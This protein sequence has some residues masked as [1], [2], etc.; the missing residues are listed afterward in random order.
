MEYLI[1]AA[2]LLHAVWVFFD[3]HKRRRHTLGEAAGWGLGTLVLWLFV[4]PLY[5]AQRH[6]RAGET[7]EGGD[8]WNYL[9]TFAVLWTIVML[10]VGAHYILAASEVA[11]TAHTSAG[12]VGAAIGATLGLGVVAAAWFFPVLGALLLGLVLK[13]A[14]IVEKGPTGP[15]ALQAPG[16]VTRGLTA[17]PT[18]GNTPLKGMPCPTCGR[19]VPPERKRHG[20]LV[21]LVVMVTGLVIGLAIVGLLRGREVPKAIPATAP[22]E[23]A[24][25]GPRA[26]AVHIAAAADQPEVNHLSFAAFKGEL[27]NECDDLEVTGSFRRGDAGPLDLEQLFAAM[28]DSP[29][30][31]AKENLLTRLKRPCGEEFRDRPPL[32]TCTFAKTHDTGTFRGRLAFYSSKAVFSSDSLMKECLSKWHGTWNAVSR[33]SEEYR[34][35][36]SLEASPGGP[37]IIS[38]GQDTLQFGKPTVKDAG[39]GMTKVMVQV[40]NVTDSQ[41]SCMVVATFMKRDTILGTANGN[42]NDLRAGFLKTAE[43]M[44][45]DQVR[46]YDT[47][48]LEPGTCF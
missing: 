40:K 1:V 14:S 16:A 15:L 12:Q 11:A 8:G 43:L 21:G 18:C 46:G 32:A 4:V 9:K 20:T 38:D 28:S 41:I 47:V 33:D 26:P 13:K 5:F 34:R 25:A 48:R 22:S 42:V 31:K 30:A 27:L 35:A 2:L 6:L 29:K 24:T 17:C 45:T 39:F 3:A 23:G 10:A 19:S 7:R 44:T 36:S 37:A